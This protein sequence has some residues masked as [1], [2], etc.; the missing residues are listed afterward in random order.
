MTLYWLSNSYAQDLSLHGVVINRLT[1]CWNRNDKSHLRGKSISEDPGEENW[2]GESK[3]ASTGR[4]GTNSLNAAFIWIQKR[5]SREKNPHFSIIA[6]HNF[7]LLTT[8][9]KLCLCWG[10]LFAWLLN[11]LSSLC[12]SYHLQ[13]HFNCKS[14][15]LLWDMVSVTSFDD[16]CCRQS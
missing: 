15:G 1:I 4:R 10:C 9:E 6:N 5:K 14:S 3:F 13:Y 8:S 12:F 16:Q 2:R 7:T 11:C